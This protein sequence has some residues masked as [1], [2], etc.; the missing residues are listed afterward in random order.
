[1]QSYNHFDVRQVLDVRLA[2]GVLDLET[3][4]PV[5]GFGSIADSTGQPVSNQDMLDFHAE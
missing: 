5:M 1:M 3:G 4:C 2:V